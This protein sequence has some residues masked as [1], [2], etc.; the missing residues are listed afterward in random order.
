MPQ[1]GLFFQNSG[2]R[3]CNGWNHPH[4]LIGGNSARGQWACGSNS[5]IQSNQVMDV[6]VI[7]PYSMSVFIKLSLLESREQKMKP[8]ASTFISIVRKRKGDQD[9]DGLTCKKWL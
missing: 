1:L 4:T 2:L 9:L 5:G 7:G 8:Y 3:E 6:I